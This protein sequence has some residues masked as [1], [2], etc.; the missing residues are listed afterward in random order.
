MTFRA[1]A[2][3]K[4]FY[5][6]RAGTNF[7]ISRCPC[8]Q[9]IHIRSAAV[10]FGDI[11]WDDNNKPQQCPPMDVQCKRSITNHTAIV[12]CNGTSN[13]CLIPRDIL[14]T[15]HSNQNGN[16]I[17]ITYDCVNSGKRKCRYFFILSINIS[18]NRYLIALLSIT[19]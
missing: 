7:R 11:E 5:D 8:D 19:K 4:E 15:C 13:R 2:G 6:C 3:A 10:G 18:V 9:V 17:K 12:A 1:A 16:F 14:P